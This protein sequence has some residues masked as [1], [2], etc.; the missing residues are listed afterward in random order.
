MARARATTNSRLSVD[1]WVQAG[2]AILAEEGIK[3]LKID[4]LCRRL[5]VTK[6][7]FYWHFT[8]IA[9]YR[10]ALVQARGELRVLMPAV[11]AAVSTINPEFAARLADRAQDAERLRRLPPATIDLIASGGSP[12]CACPFATAAYR[13]AF[14]PSSIASAG[15]RMDARPARGRSASTRRTTGYCGPDDGIY[16]ALALLPAGGDA[17]ARQR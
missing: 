3:A 11:S 10:A 7:S 13:P 5:G 15:W 17:R 1:D 2:F 8:A 14:R 12:N 4:R 9:G 6:G 16:P